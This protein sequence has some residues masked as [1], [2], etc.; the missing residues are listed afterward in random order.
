[1]NKTQAKIIDGDSKITHLEELIENYK[2]KT[3]DRINEAQEG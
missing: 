3:K 2:N 1:M